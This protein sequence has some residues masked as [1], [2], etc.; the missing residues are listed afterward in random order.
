MFDAVMTVSDDS[1]E[2]LRFAF[3]G[4]DVAVVPYSIDPDLFHPSTGHPAEAAR[5]DAPQTP[6]GCGQIVRLL[7]DRLAAWEVVRIE[8]VSEEETAALLRS[9]PIFLA[10]GKEEGF[11]LPAAEA[12][13]SGCYVIGFSGFGGRVLFDPSWSTPVEDGDLLSAARAVAT[14]MADFEREP[15]VVRSA[16]AVASENILGRFTP[17]RQ[18]QDL[19]AFHRQIAEKRC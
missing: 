10:L 12:M 11:G 8:G 1:A 16:A 9:S 5:P 17:Q 4:L 6:K 3:P 7:G 2:L 13:A 14:T 18:L 15:N 19:I